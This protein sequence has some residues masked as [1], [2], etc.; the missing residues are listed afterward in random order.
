MKKEIDKKLLIRYINDRCTPEDMIQVKQFLQDPEWQ[1]ALEKLLE[2]DF[3]AMEN[4]QPDETAVEEWNQQFRDKYFR[5]KS[6]RFWSTQWTGYAAAC[7]VL[8]GIGGYF[9]AGPLGVTRQ[10]TTTVNAMIEKTNPRGIRSR[11]MLPDSSVVYLGAGSSISFPE[12][13]AVKER[14]LTL[15]G[16]AF[17]EVSKNPE[18]PF[19]IYTD[20]IRTTVLGTSF[21]ITAFK[22]DPLSVEVA[23]GKVR[24]SRMERGK[25]ATE[26]AV[27]IP[28]E[29]IRWDGKSEKAVAISADIRAVKGWATGEIS[30]RNRSLAQ[31]AAELENWYDV[32]ISFAKSVRGN[33][34]LSLS[35]DGR[36]ALSDVLD[37]ICNTAH[38]EYYFNGRQKVVISGSK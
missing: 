22:G 34:R 29:G 9:L 2:V 26:L 24:V 28:G 35:V 25:G 33:K 11:I 10:A 13:F 19:V 8:L 6:V 27:L 1:Q 36:L 30:F 7:L 38:L 14:M 23:T 31:I 20:K 5:K 37:I 18:R 15:T 12:R 16:E 17:F 21:K 32:D 4:E 3:S